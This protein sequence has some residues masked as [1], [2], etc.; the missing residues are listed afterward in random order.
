MRLESV[1]G[2][3]LRVFGLGSEGKWKLLGSF[4]LGCDQVKFILE[5]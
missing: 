1:F 3:T 2:E 5:N 4:N